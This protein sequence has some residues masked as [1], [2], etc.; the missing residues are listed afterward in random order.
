M[1][2]KLTLKTPDGESAESLPFAMRNTAVRRQ[3]NPGFGQASRSRGNRQCDV[4]SHF[5]AGFGSHPFEDHEKWLW[6]GCLPR[7]RHHNFYRHIGLN[8]IR[9]ERC[10][11]F[12]CVV[13]DNLERTF[14]NLPEVFDHR[15]CAPE[16]SPSPFGRR[17]RFRNEDGRRRVPDERLDGLDVVPV[18]R[19]DQIAIERLDRMFSDGI[20]GYRFVSRL[21]GSL[22]YTGYQCDTHRARDRANA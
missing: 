15:I 1:V 4:G 18:F 2:L 17:C 12:V 9:R 16:A 14:V 19:L 5:P 20:K 8:D 3:P 10:F 7:V 11:P 13:G 6:H 22:S 21:G